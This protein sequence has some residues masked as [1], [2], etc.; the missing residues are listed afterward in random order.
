MIEIQR[1]AGGVT[2]RGHARYA[3]PGKDIVCSAISALSQTL[4]A[5]IE[6]LT[7]DKIEYD[8][9]PGTVEIRHG[10]LSGAAL[11]LIDSFFVGAGMIA[12]Q[13]PENVCILN[14]SEIPNG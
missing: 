5:S 2:V 7:A 13:Y 8:I 12:E 10:N 14:G 3:E 1:T 6:G 4:I 9:Q 11:L